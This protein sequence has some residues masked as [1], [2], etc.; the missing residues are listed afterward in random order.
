MGHPTR[1]GIL[2]LFNNKQKSKMTVTQIYDELGLTQPDTSRHLYILKNSSVL[3][4]EKDASNSFYFINEEHFF[5][6]CIANCM[7]K[8]KDDNIFGN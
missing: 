7:S 3:H 6:H 4:C 2:I 8:Y 5:I 1:I